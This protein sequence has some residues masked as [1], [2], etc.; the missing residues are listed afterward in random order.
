M[1]NNNNKD[2]QINNDG[3]N[4]KEFFKKSIGDKQDLNPVSSN[5]ENSELF[6]YL[7]LQFKKPLFIR[8][9]D[10]VQYL[11][12]ISLKAIFSNNKHYVKFRSMMPFLFNDDEKDDYKMKEIFN[13]ELKI[14]NEIYSKDQINNL[15][16]KLILP[17]VDA[18][19]E[20]LKYFEQNVKNIITSVLIPFPKLKEII[21]KYFILKDNKEYIFLSP[22]DSLINFKTE[23]SIFGNIFGILQIVT[24]LTKSD[25]NVKFQYELN[26]NNNEFGYA[27]LKCMCFADFKNRPTFEL[28]LGFLIYRMKYY[29][30]DSISINK[31]SSIIFKIMLE[32]AFNLG[33][34]IKCDHILNYSEEIVRSTWNIL[35]FTDAIISLYTGES[36]KIDYKY[37]I[38]R[39][40]EYWEPIVLYLRNVI[41]TFNSTDPI[42]LNMIIDLANSSAK[43]LYVFQPFNELLND[44]ICSPVQYSLSILIKGD[45]V[46]CYQL[47]LFILRLSIDEIN[48]LP[49]KINENEIK[50]INELKI[51]IECHLFYSLFLTFEL[52]KKIISGNML[53]FDQSTRLTI[54]LRLLFSRFMIIGNKIIF[55]YLSVFNSNN[56]TKSILMPINEFEKEKE[57]FNNNFNY[58]F[59]YDFNFNLKSKS[60]S[61][62]S[63]IL[64]IES[65]NYLCKGLDGID[66]NDKEFKKMGKLMKSLPDLSDYL[67]EFYL[68][69]SSKREII[70]SGKFKFCFKFLLYICLLLKNVYEFEIYLNNSFNKNLIKE[71]YNNKKM[72]YWKF[73]IDKTTEYYKTIDQFE[74][75]L[76]EIKNKWNCISSL[77]SLKQGDLLNNTVH[78]SEIGEEELNELYNMFF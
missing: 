1:N 11:S 3:N 29:I 53:F 48:Q 72:E 55:C 46:I 57:N 35:Q 56:F 51:K 73:L 69:V 28:L 52:M 12:P 78:V 31:N 71:D 26:L 17:N 64:L 58:N 27:A 65:E 36:L 16:I 47:L 41:T 7:T 10:S 21:N 38:P 43:L 32:I 49:I 70:L 76:D 60:D 68:I 67:F 13:Q 25:K 54:S 30:L 14:F 8:D 50:L 59:N 6:N 75:N 22:N 19:I 40:Y 42:S 37:C 5:K 20:R 33:I 34:H 23:Y 74:L 18:I 62:F 2:N 15:L 61:K 4:V 77:W 63:D 39:L 24:I 66:I 45:F 9:G 44:K